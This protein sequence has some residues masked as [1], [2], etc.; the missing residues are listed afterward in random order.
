L[1]PDRHNGAEAFIRDRV[2]KKLRDQVEERARLVDAGKEKQAPAIE[3][4]F[5]AG[6][7]ALLDRLGRPAEERSG[8]IA[9]REL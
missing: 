5:I 6:L 7:R 2:F 3:P 8:Y 4:P 9:V 1:Q